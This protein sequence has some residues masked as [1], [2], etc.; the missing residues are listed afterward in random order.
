MSSASP[1][2]SRRPSRE[3]TRTRLL[4]AAAK[5][6]AG[7][8][9]GAASIEDICEAA[10]FSRGAFYSNFDAK[11]DLVLELLI[12]HTEQNMAELER[13]YE[14]SDG[15]IA[16]LTAMESPE[17]QRFGPLDIENGHLLRL[18]LMLH[19]ARN[20]DLRPRLQAYHRRLRELNSQ[21]IERISATSQREYPVP[22]DDVVSIVMGLDEGF[23]M[24]DV[25][26]PES[27]RPGQF[28]EAMV[29]L[30]EMWMSEGDGPSQ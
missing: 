14:S 11:A 17:R 19:A 15:P 9:I 21:I 26:D 5:L 23:A 13:I 22:L 27:I 24:L 18:E 3:E 16:F 2:R 25:V 20:P 8:G 30:H 10:G 12:A 29:L 7:Q 1:K 6:F 4:E 28:S